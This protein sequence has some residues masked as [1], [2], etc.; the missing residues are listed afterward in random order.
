MI[1][2]IQ[3][4]VLKPLSSITRRE[5]FQDAMYEAQW[6]SDLGVVFGEHDVFDPDSLIVSMEHF[7]VAVTTSLRVILNWLSTPTTGRATGKRDYGQKDPYAF[8]RDSHMNAPMAVPSGM[9]WF[10]VLQTTLEGIES[11]NGPDFY[12]KNVWNYGN[13]MLVA[14]ELQNATLTA[15]NELICKQKHQTGFCTI[16]RSGFDPG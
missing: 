6:N 12:E 3:E 14:I 2:H 5:E 4:E 11:S 9:S 8:F 16:E 7:K 1:S 15:A 13:E 10:E